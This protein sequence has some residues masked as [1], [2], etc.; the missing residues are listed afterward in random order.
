M[1][2]IFSRMQEL[3]CSL[4]DCRLLYTTAKMCTVIPVQHFVVIYEFIYQNSKLFSLVEVPSDEWE[5]F[6]NEQPS[7]SLR[8]LLWGEPPTSLFWRPL[9]RVKKSCAELFLKC[10]CRHNKSMKKKIFSYKYKC[11]K[12]HINV[13]F[14]P[15]LHL[16]EL[17]DI[18]QVIRLWKSS[19]FQSVLKYLFNWI[20]L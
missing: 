12:W 11:S 6:T 8:V 2:C 19:S 17:H 20:N 10:C 9:A 16:E 5:H 13:Q 14:F 7:L 18:K 3:S 4:K 15:F 1:F